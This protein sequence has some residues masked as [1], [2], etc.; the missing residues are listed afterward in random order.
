MV[1]LTC[2]YYVLR[3]TYATTYY[4]LL[5]AWSEEAAHHQLKASRS[6][7][8]LQHQKSDHERELATAEEA[9]RQAQAEA[10]LLENEANSGKRG[11][12]EWMC[13]AEW[14]M[15]EEPMRRALELAYQ[16]NSLQNTVPFTVGLIIYEAR[17]PAWLQA[18]TDGNY[19][20]TRNIRRR[21]VDTE[22]AAK[23][24]AAEQA[25]VAAESAVQKAKQQTEKAIPEDLNL[26]NNLA[27]HM[28]T[29]N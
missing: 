1:L 2:T 13:G 19:D 23:V 21:V 4:L 3:P 16:K 12:W 18:R 24:A 15:Y 8:E 22:A 14:V 25:K 27:Q 20:T 11:I 28:Q 5:G 7:V 9:R 10:V 6:E 17:W 26:W 29:P